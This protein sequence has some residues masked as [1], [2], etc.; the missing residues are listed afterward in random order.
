EPSVCTVIS[1]APLGATRIP[2]GSLRSIS[3]KPSASFGG[4]TAQPGVKPW[5]LKLAIVAHLLAVTG[6]RPLPS[7]AGKAK[8]HRLE[9]P[10]GRFE[11]RIQFGSTPIQLNQSDLDDGCLSVVLTKPR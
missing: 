6:V 9:I 5:D 11:R 2:G 8:I 1:V 7:I 4:Q 10:Y 3:T